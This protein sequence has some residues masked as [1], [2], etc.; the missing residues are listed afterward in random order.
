MD[1]TE[2]TELTALLAKL[3]QHR[4]RGEIIVFTNGC[5]DILHRGHA[6]YLQAARD[7]GDL[8]VIGVNTDASVKRLKGDS[9]PINNEDDR[10]FILQSLACVD[11]VIKFGEDTPHELLS[12]IKPDILVKGGDYKLEEVVGREFARQV[13][14]IDFVDGYSTTKTIRKM[15][16]TQS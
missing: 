8:L 10:A 15:K 7:L 13:V 16:E 9:R 3:D 5:F 1:K 12:Q 4:T 2:T 6:S 11:Y 14:L